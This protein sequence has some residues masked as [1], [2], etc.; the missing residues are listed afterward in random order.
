MSKE[1]MNENKDD[2]HFIGSLIPLGKILDQVR[3]VKCKSII[4]NYEAEEA[5]K[6]DLS[7]KINEIDI[8]DNA[9]SNRVLSTSLERLICDSR[10]GDSKLSLEEISQIPIID[11]PG[12]P[13]PIPTRPIFFDILYVFPDL[14]TTASRI[15]KY[16]PRLRKPQQTN[17]LAG[18]EGSLNDTQ[19][20]SS[21][22]QNDTLSI[23]DMKYQ[24]LWAV[25]K[26][27]VQKF[28][29]SWPTSYLGRREAE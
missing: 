3:T 6:D 17:L 21:L 4:L 18:G 14:V 13:Q 23:E 26:G 29:G 24:V 25:A 22:I 20:D 8:N 19:F 11:L 27:S 10:E 12:R 1:E 15:P 9:E 5:K 7:K 16:R 2:D 28:H